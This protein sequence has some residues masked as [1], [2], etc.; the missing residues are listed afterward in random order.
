MEALENLWSLEIVFK[1]SGCDTAS[2]VADFPM[3]PDFATA[4]RMWRSRRAA[5]YDDRTSRRMT[6]RHRT[7]SQGAARWSSY[8]D[9]CSGNQ[10]GIRRIRGL[11]TAAKAL[12]RF[13][14]QPNAREN[15][16]SCR[17]RPELK[18]RR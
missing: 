14:M 8:P 16:A 10:Q 17:R 4:S 9:P 12:K 11:C 18:E 13:E 5:D 15:V 3:L 6:I 2:S 7:S 1:M